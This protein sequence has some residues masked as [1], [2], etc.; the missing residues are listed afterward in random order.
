MS[1]SRKLADLLDVNGDV[2]S[3]NLDNVSEFKLFQLIP[4][5]PAPAA[6]SPVDTVPPADD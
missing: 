6:V 2:K 4:L 3:A 5:P 1:R